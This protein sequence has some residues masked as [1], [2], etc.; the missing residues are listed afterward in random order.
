MHLGCHQTNASK[1]NLSALC[2]LSLSLT[3]TH[4]KRERNSGMCILVPFLSFS[5]SSVCWTNAF[6]WFS[7]CFLST[8][9]FCSSLNRS[10]TITTNLFKML[11]QWKGGM[12][13]AKLQAREVVSN[14][15]LHKKE[16]T[17]TSETGVPLGGVDLGL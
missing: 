11:H 16:H 8:S 6:C 5:F 3:H 14:G 7:A 4:R 2:S 10:V 12:M 1:A 17:E 15:D 13:N 9:A